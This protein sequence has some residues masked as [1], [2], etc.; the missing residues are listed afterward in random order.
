MLIHCQ[1]GASRSASLIIAYGM[2]QNPDLSVNGAYHKAQSK[3]KWISPN[4]RLMYCLQDFQKEVVKRRLSPG[5]AFRA[6]RSMRSPTK[7]RATLSADDAVMTKEPSTA[8]LPAEDM[9]PVVGNAGPERSPNRIRAD[10][11]PI[12]RELASPGPSSAPSSVSWSD[13]GDDR[14]PGSFAPDVP[15]KQSGLFSPTK[16]SFGSLDTM[17]LPPATPVHLSPCFPPKLHSPRFGSFDPSFA[18]LD[19]LARPPPSPGFLPPSWGS[20]PRPPPSPGFPPLSFGARFMPPPPASFA[21]H[22]VGKSSY[23]AGMPPL[24]TSGLGIRDPR[25]MQRRP[26]SRLLRSLPDD[27]TLM[28]PRAETMTKNPLHA[29]GSAF[30]SHTDVLASAG[31]AGLTFVEIPPTPDEGLFSPRQTLFPPRYPSQTADPRSPPTKGET[32]IVRSIDEIL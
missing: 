25:G 11:T 27:P 2:Y 12:Y 5:F 22:R 21:D 31:L 9:P 23:V 18:S 26:V 24:N 7:H 3:S 17:Y 14:D 20:L 32:P 19:S 15:L 6:G 10:S 16:L 13:K 4:M 28:S 8:P 1:Q 30:G 29:D